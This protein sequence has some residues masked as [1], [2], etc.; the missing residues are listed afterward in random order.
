MISWILGV[1]VERNRKLRQ[2]SLSQELF[3]A[4]LLARH[5][6]F[7]AAGT[8]APRARTQHQNIIAA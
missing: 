1:K 2:I 8:V 5:A 6:P 4:D 3:V 7:I